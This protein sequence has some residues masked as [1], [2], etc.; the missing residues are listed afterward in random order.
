[1][2][3]YGEADIISSSRIVGKMRVQHIF[4][5]QAIF[6]RLGLTLGC[7]LNDSGSS[8]DDPERPRGN[9]QLRELAGELRLAQNSK[10][11]GVLVWMENRSNV[12]STNYAYENQLRLAC[13]L[14]GNRL[15]MIEH[16]RDGGEPVFWLALWPTMFDGDSQIDAR[17]DPFRISIPRDRWL[18][19]LGSVRG[20][21]RSIL[22]MPQ[23]V[24]LPESVA[25]CTKH[26]EAG[27]KQLDEGHFDDV[28]VS[29]RRA[30]EAL[31]TVVSIPNEVPKLTEWL[32]SIVEPKRAKPYANIVGSLKTLGNR[33]VHHGSSA[34]FTRTEASFV[35]TTTSL[36][37]GLVAALMERRTSDAT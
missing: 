10:A 3:S 16:L 24:E 11:V 20:S 26:L 21:F 22:E 17:V 28:V 29:S 5:P 30:I 31:M 35:I 34:S 8:V 7:A 33:A 27:L 25:S 1:M 14:D 9:L 32:E 6:P 23:P 19:Y 4:D 15:Q 13:D 12:R 2:S 36:I 18:E 37:V